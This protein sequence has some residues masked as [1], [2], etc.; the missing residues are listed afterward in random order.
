MTDSVKVIYTEGDANASVVAS[1]VA[2]LREAIQQDNL[3]A[4]A[5]KDKDTGADA[6]L[7]TVVSTNHESGNMQYSPI[8]ELFYP[9]DESFMRMIPPTNAI[10]A[11]E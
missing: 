11:S 9:E 5:C 8:A 3:V 7:L 4:V 1:R 10:T 2:I 6:I